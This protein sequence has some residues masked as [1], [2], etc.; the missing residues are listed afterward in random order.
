[1][2]SSPEVPLRGKHR[3]FPAEEKTRTLE[4]Y[5]SAS[6]PIERAAAIRRAGPYSSL[7]SNW[8]QPLTTAPTQQS[9]VRRP[10][11]MHLKLRS[12]I[13]KTHTSSGGFR[14]PESMLHALGNV[15]AL[16]QRLQARA[17]RTSSRRRNPKRARSDRRHPRGMSARRTRRHLDALVALH[18]KR[19]STPH[20]DRSADLSVREAHAT[21]LDEVYLGSPSPPCGP[22]HRYSIG[23]FWCA[24]RAHARQLPFD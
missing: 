16:L 3:S 23:P 21:L 14:S 1:M 12:Y 7:I 13:K 19:F 2:S 11:L 4:E 20:G 22:A 17:R 15:H 10:I 6:T 5:E 18:V 9:A 24:R 8:S